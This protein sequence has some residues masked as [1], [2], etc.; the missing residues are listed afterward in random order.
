MKI[1]QRKLSSYC[2]LNYD[3]NKKL[4]NLPFRNELIENR[5]NIKIIN[6]SKSTNL[7]NSIIKINQINLKNKILYLVEILKN[8]L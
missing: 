6:D 1:L 7:E 3:H 2:K 4:K 8:Q 5:S